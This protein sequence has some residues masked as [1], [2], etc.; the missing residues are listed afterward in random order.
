MRE[1]VVLK[2]SR[3][4]RS[5]PM[6]VVGAQ[7][8]PHDQGE[9]AAQQGVQNLHGVRPAAA[10]GPSGDGESAPQKRESNTSALSNVK[11]LVQSLLVLSPEAYLA[12][13][14]EV[15]M[16]WQLMENEH[17]VRDID[18]VTL[19]SVLHND[20]DMSES[21]TLMTVTR[22]WADDLRKTSRLAEECAYDKQMHE[23]VGMLDKCYRRHR[24]GGAADRS[25]GTAAPGCCDVQ[26]LK[27]CLDSERERDR[28][29]QNNPAQWHIFFQE[30]IKARSLVRILCSWAV[31]HGCEQ[32]SESIYIAASLLKALS[33][34]L[35][36]V[37]VADTDAD[38]NGGQ[39]MLLCGGA[40][41]V[42]GADVQAQNDFPLQGYLEAFLW[43][44][45]PQKGLEE[46]EM[47][48]VEGLIAELIRVNV[49]CHDSWVQSLIS[50]GAFLSRHS[51]R[52]VW[53]LSAGDASWGAAMARSS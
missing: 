13:S 3:D 50:K 36:Q 22:P 30:H 1:C 40:E 19:K 21:S 17:S 9:R 11:R 34:A 27:E 35:T 8:V 33:E 39:E 28:L 24:S 16:A 43:S 7:Q 37:L 38:P 49:F 26:K 31:R 10:G 5:D 6:D 48:R 12:L 4:A 42:V 23:L 51:H 18:A 45:A 14:P 15:Q 20:V 41:G 44:F 46:D 53:L 2:P 32:M 47:L 25:G 29:R 52:Q